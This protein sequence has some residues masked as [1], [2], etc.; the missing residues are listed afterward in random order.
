MY[1][2]LLFAGVAFGPTLGAVL[3]E[4]TDNIL[5]VFYLGAGGY[6][7]YIIFLAFI[8]PESLSVDAR[9]AIS[10]RRDKAREERRASRE[11][12]SLTWGYLA[13]L[14]SQSLIFLAPLAIFL[15]RQTNEPGKKG[16][17]W[18]LTFVAI[19]FAIFTSL[20]VGAF[21]CVIR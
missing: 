16:K 11:A 9:E 13:Q 5:S 4:T 8:V 1:Y 14:A 18:N 7:A 10:E 12:P 15:P 3:V 6:F 21:V 17:D 19:A 2:G 20:Q